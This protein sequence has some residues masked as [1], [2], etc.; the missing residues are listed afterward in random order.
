V[1][2]VII[3]NGV[4]GVTA[5]LTL[6]ARE[7][8]AEITMVSGESDYFFS[9][10]ALMYAYMDR[11][12]LGDL[13]PYE[14]KVFAK[15][16]IGLVRDWVVDLDATE[17]ILKL[18]SGRSLEYDRL[19][20][21]V[22]SLGTRPDWPGLENAREGVAH[23]VTLQDL[24]QC[25]R[26]TPSTREAVVVGGGLIGVELVE[27][28]VFHGEKVTYLVRSPWYW[29]GAL[30][31]EESEIVTEHIRR[32]GVDLHGTEEVAEVLCGTDGRV[33]GV[34][35]MSGAEFGCQ[36]LGI[37]I[38]VSP[39][40]DWLR[41]AKTPP[42]IERGILVSPSFETS[43]PGV[44]AAGDCAEFAQDGEWMVEQIWYS[45]KRQ[46]ELAARA[47]LGDPVRY[48]PPIF[49]NS[50]KFFE[51]EYTSTGSIGKPPENSRTFFCRIPGKEASVRIVEQNGAVIGVN[52]LGARWDQTFFERWIAE[53]RA[54]DYVVEHLRE[55]QF[56]VEF[57]RV[58]LAAVE[59]SYKQWRGRVSS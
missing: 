11:M 44:W 49:Y 13:E 57:A 55:A 25:E 16:R 33:R 23:F 22:G 43:L 4:A 26:L 24:Q 10:T 9:R 2:Y 42:K 27:C 38:G 14:R 58:D 12:S 56:D 51:I 34:R 45:A 5:A 35:T 19:L 1:R 18:K 41:A 15:Q 20:L 8:E 21:A 7:P 3:G 53:R 32:H 30:A 50:A 17:Q 6:R 37:A 40:V 54:M 52:M 31:K 47:M 39:A 59:A 29:P 46:G 36:M 48:E 28:L